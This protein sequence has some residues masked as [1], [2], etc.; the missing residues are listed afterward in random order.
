ME[1]EFLITQDKSYTI[2]L[3]ALNVT[4]HSKYGSIQE[5]NHVFIQ[6][7]IEYYQSLLNKNNL[8]IF[9]MGF[10]TGLNALLSY[11]FALKNNIAIY[12]SGLELYPISLQDATKLNYGQLLNAENTF[13]QLHTCAWQKKYVFNKNFS[14][15]KIQTSLLTYHH[16]QLYD[17][18][19][20]DAFAPA[21]QPELWTKDIFD[22]LF[23]MLLPSGI[24]VTYCSKSYVRK[25]MEAT[26]FTIQKIPGPVGKREMI[27][28]V[29][30]CTR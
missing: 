19:F 3:P 29:K 21:A 7:G 27:R 22:K 8:M 16:H 14:F 12:Y 1:K 28:A 24:L 20:Y 13:L 9:E 17:I 25:N 26:G 15:L 10:G 30:N 4:Y 23:S 5:S 18:I 2:A 11:Q 6:A